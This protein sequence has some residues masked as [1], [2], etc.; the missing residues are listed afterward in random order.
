MS[1]RSSSAMQSAAATDR[2]K[3]SFTLDAVRC[4]AMRFGVLR[5]AAKK[6]QHAARCHTATQRT[7]SVQRYQV[8]LLLLLI[9]IKTH[10]AYIMLKS[11]QSP[12]DRATLR[13]I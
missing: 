13:A 7:L 3:A 6:T 12:R 10:T 4:V 5:C 11:E 9:G 8:R 1:I 2:S